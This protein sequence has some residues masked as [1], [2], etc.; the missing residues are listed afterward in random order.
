MTLTQSDGYQ[1]QNMK[2]FML[3]LKT[4]IVLK[5]EKNF[6]TFMIPQQFR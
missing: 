3:L 5:S 2:E 6:L 1:E 4:L